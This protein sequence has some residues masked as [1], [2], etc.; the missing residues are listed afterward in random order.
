MSQAIVAVLDEAAKEPGT[1]FPN[2]SVALVQGGRLS[3]GLSG[4][5]SVHL[6]HLS[7]G[8]AIF[9]PP[10]AG[11]PGPAALVVDLH[12]LVTAW[13]ETADVQQRLLGWC[14][15]TLHGA[16]VLP[17]DLL[18]RPGE[19][20]FGP[21]EAV[22]LQLEPLTA[23]E[24]REVWPAADSSLQPSLAYCVRSLQIR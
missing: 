10:P 21:T 16:P 13:A 6:R 18:N 3:E 8:R 19:E 15:R 1:E 11:E 2:L 17:A 4:G 23:A 9:N 5:L 24:L 22:G 20:V 14:L 7:A 12:Y